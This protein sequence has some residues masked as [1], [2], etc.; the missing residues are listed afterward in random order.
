MSTRWTRNPKLYKLVKRERLGK[1]VKYKASSYLFICF[2]V[3]LDTSYWLIDWLLLQ[4][5][6]A[7]EYAEFCC[8][9]DWFCEPDDEESV[10]FPHEHLHV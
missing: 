3:I 2:F 8:E 9:V 4:H 10:S 5:A 6:C 7:C 1:Y